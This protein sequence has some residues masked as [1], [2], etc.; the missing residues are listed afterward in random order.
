MS[1]E[2]EKKIKE[3]FRKQAAGFS[4][5]SLTLNQED[6]LTWILDSLDLEKG[7]SVLDVAGGTGILSQSIA[8]FVNR[9][10]SIDISQEMINEGMKQTGQKGISNI[11]FRIAHAENLPFKQ[12]S[13]ELVVSRLGFHHFTNPN[14][15][16]Q[17]M[18]KV[19]V[20]N[21]AVGVIDMIS[22]EDNELHRLYN[23]YER[24][25]DPSHSSAL[26][27]SQFIELFKNTGLEINQVEVVDVPVHLKRWLALTKTDNQIKEQIIHDINHEI[28]TG[29]EITG[30]SPYNRKRGSDV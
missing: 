13:F 3:Q 28:D 16:L 23:H 7:M 10:T 12:E 1:K 8:P 4:N 30:L 22:P 18:S 17:E 6:L 11:A 9:V 24:L 21:G 15:I 14:R 25:R 29:N 5:K 26:K 2:H 20:R 27:K 19:C